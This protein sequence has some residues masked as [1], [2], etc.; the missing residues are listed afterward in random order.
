MKHTQEVYQSVL[1][2]V[3]MQLQLE[4]PQRHPLGQIKSLDGGTVA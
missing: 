2:A 4:L 1:Q 3:K